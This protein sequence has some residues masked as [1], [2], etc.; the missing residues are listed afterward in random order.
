[1][2]T[3]FQFTGGV[4]ATDVD[5]VIKTFVNQRFFSIDASGKVAYQ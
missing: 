4:S 2:S 3:L 5:K 1:M